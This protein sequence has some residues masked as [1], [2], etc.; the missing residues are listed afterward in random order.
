[1]G[2]LKR[3]GRVLGGGLLAIVALS[4]C[5]EKVYDYS[6]EYEFLVGRDC[7][8]LD[9]ST[10]NTLEV[11]AASDSSA[12]RGYR[13]R[14]PIAA[15]MELPAISV[16]ASPNDAGELTVFF[17]KEKDGMM[18]YQS[19]Q[20]MVMTLVP[21]PSKPD[22]LWLTRWTLSTQN[23]IGASNER[24]MLDLLLKSSRAQAESSLTD[25]IDLTNSHACLG[26]KNRLT[27]AERA[28]LEEETVR[29]QAQRVADQVSRLEALTFEEFQAIGPD[30]NM[31]PA[32]PV[33][34]AYVEQ[35]GQRAAA[36]KKRELGRLSGL[37]D[38]ALEVEA[39]ACRRNREPHCLAIAEIVGERRTVALAAEK[40]RLVAMSY[41]AFADHKRVSCASDR[42]EECKMYRSLE[43]QKWQ[44]EIARFLSVYDGEELV[45]LEWSACNSA[46]PTYREDR[47][48]CNKRREVTRIKR[49]HQARYYEGHPDELRETYNTCIDELDN[50]TTARNSKE[51]QDIRY[52]FR[53]STA[54]EGARK[55][56]IRG[57]FR[58]R[59]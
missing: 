34:R 47:H 55:A 6:G 57:V 16:Q 40:S 59:M 12:G 32:T 8:L 39:R 41:S 22:H 10:G 58:T 35:A 46:S 36:E 42:T 19:S 7:T 17:N 56:G 50:L 37:S 54:L 51:S 31:T 14:L 52:T 28:A 25:S 13:V 11:A 29:Q 44:E 9:S 49:S 5:A 43:D 21:H 26:K 38:T 20:T 24:D 4:G 30:C 53:C 18:G 2:Y 15:N 3:T 23:N 45:N 48:Q 33:C 27:L 1:M